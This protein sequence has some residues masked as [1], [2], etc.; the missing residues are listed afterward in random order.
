KADRV[1][2]EL[3]RRGTFVYRTRPPPLELV[4]PL[5][6]AAD[7]H[8]I[9]LRD[10]FVGFVVP[11]KVHACIESGKRIIFVGS[12]SSDVHLLASC[13][14]APQN[15]RQVDIGNIDGLVNVLHKMECAVVDEHKS[16]AAASHSG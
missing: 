10:A 1:E 8:L 7:V 2:N 4:P 13:A 14:L 12:K 9:T 6:M 11:L 5:L 3:R 15:Y 16:R